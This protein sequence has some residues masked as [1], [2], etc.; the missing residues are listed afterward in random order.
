[1]SDYI[2]D[3]QTTLYN[4]ATVQSL[5]AS[6]IASSTTEYAI[7]NDELIPSNIGT[8]SGVLNLTVNDSTVNYYEASPLDDSHPLTDT[9]ITA[10]CRASTRSKV[11]ALRDAV[12]TALNRKRVNDSFFVCSRLSIIPPADE[13]D[14]FNAPVEV[15]ILNKKG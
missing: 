1:M 4:D 14:N 9:T 13:N 11:K 8:D 7:F 2:T 5:V 15:K 12:A 6:F 3:F 10:S